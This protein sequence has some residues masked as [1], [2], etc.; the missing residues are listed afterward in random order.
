MA[1]RLF[2]LLIS[3]L[4]GVAFKANYLSATDTVLTKVS[5]YEAVETV[6]ESEILEN[7]VIETSSPSIESVVNYAIPVVLNHYTVTNVTS[8]IVEYPNYY[9]IYRTGK[10]LYAHD[11]SNLFGNI[12]YINIGDTVVITEAGVSRNYIV[13]DKVVYAKIDGLLDGSVK[14]TKNVEYEA[15]GY[16]LSMMTCY[17]THYGNGDASHRMVLFLNAA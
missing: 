4:I 17:G 14:V 10:F 16:D 12:P 2:L 5:G 3:S 1:K 15:N 8:S 6:I 7:N 11:M 9:D 13:M